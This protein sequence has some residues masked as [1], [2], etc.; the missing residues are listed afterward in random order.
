MSYPFFS[1]VWYQGFWMSIYR[2]HDSHPLPCPTWGHI[3]TWI[4]PG[5]HCLST[6]RNF[7]PGL[8]LPYHHPLHFPYC[9]AS[10]IVFHIASYVISCLYH[11]R[12]LLPAPE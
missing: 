12:I 3:S 1:D 9:D 8:L 4:F 2:R 7:I 11:G 6:A 10:S 5:F